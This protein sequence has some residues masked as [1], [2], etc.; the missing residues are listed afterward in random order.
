MNQVKNKI[1][2]VILGKIGA[3]VE[4]IDEKQVS[5]HTV[6]RRPACTLDPRPQR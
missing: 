3:F 4:G 6:S 1:R 5:T 2:D